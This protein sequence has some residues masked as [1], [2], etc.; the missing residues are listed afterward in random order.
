VRGARA[1]FLVLDAGDPSL[2]GVPPSHTLDALVFSSP[3]DAIRDVF[4]GGHAVVR[5][6]RHP[7]QDAIAARFASAMHAIWEPARR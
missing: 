7:A 3:G 6:R 2:I 4:V 1:D 5:N